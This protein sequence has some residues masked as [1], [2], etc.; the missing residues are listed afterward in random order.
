MI[1]Y[2]SLLHKNFFKQ[3]AF[4]LLRTS[5]GKNMS[6]NCQKISSLLLLLY[7]KFTDPQRVCDPASELD[8]INCQTPPRLLI[9]TAPRQEF[10]AKE[11]PD[12]LPPLLLFCP[13]NTSICPHRF[14][15]LR[16]LSRRSRRTRPMRRATINGCLAPV[17]APRSPGPPHDI[18]HRL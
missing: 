14:L 15:F 17:A 5:Y 8:P 4:F 1:R 10:P 3:H 13:F 6:S 16:T 11:P 12:H 2:P 7:S 18:R 9:P